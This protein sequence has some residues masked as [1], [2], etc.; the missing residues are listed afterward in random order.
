MTNVILSVYINHIEHIGHI[1]FLKT[2]AFALCV[3]CFYV[4]KKQSPSGYPE[5]LSISC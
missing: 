5:E 1:V 2:L 4:V 3:L